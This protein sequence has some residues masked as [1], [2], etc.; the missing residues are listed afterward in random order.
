VTS[1]DVDRLIRTE[2]WPFVRGHGFVVRGR[3][4]RRYCPDVDHVINFQSYA[5]HQATVHG[6]TSFS[7]QVN[8]GAWPVFMPDEYE[9]RCDE[10]G[11]LLVHEYECL[12]R[13]HVEPTVAEPA[14]RRSLNPFAFRPLPRPTATWAVA[15]DGAN[16][17]E[18]V[19]DAR[20]GI[21]SQALPWFEARRTAGQM[22]D[23][24][25][26]EF[27]SPMLEYVIRLAAARAGDRSVARENLQRALNSGAF[28]EHADELQE[29]LD[30]L[31]L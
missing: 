1:K 28:L 3:T 18:C 30:R 14:R 17:T 20:D 25:R 11:R 29:A 6:I 27:V 7:F 31:A 22:I 16:A 4:A 15:A 23:V 10:R 19:V 13:H 12:F 24:A 5:S 2:V 8:L 26:A 9:L 21:E